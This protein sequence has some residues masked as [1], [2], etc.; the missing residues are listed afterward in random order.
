MPC[1]GH[2]VA[3]QGT[4][5]VFVTVIQNFADSRVRVRGRFV[6]KNQESM[7]TITLDETV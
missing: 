3:D 5:S 6:K 2:A 7:N 1:G 4:P